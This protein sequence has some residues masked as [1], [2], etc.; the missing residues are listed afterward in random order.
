MAGVASAGQGRRPPERSENP[1]G[2][3]R[4]L[5]GVGAVVHGPAVVICLQGT[6]MC[7]KEPMLASGV[8]NSESERTALP[9]HAT[10]PLCHTADAVLTEAA[11]TAGGEW[12]C[13]T[14]SAHWDAV[15]MAKVAAYRGWLREHLPTAPTR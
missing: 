4:D 13:L 10:C 6:A 2:V 7:T 14:C 9:P 11:L 8:A 12:R 5:R 15:R 3:L 1:R